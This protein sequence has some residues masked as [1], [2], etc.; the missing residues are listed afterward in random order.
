MGRDRGGPNATSI[1]TDVVEGKSLVETS[2]SGEWCYRLST[3]GLSL[4]SLLA[5]LLPLPLHLLGLALVLPL[6]PPH[7][8]LVPLLRIIQPLFVLIA[9]FALILLTARIGPIERL[10]TQLAR[11]ALV[12]LRLEPRPFR[13]RHDL[14]AVLDQVLALGHLHLRLRE[15]LFGLFFLQDLLDFIRQILRL[16][17]PVICHGHVDDPADDLGALRFARFHGRLDD[18]AIGLGGDS[19]CATGAARTRGTTDSVHVDLMALRG[20]V[21]DDRFHALDIQTTRRQVGCQEEGDF[22][23]PEV[24]H[25]FDTLEAG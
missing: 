25:A 6:L 21:V 12:P 8:A 9:Q 3:H 16:L 17:G 13:P 11:R 5:L 7:R 23:I 18:L 4:A 15:L 2:E 19:A 20:L 14:A 10:G 24:L 22:S 1:C